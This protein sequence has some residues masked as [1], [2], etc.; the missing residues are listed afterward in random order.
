[1]N[2]SNKTSTGKYAQKIKDL[3]EFTDLHFI[4]L[5]HYPTMSIH[6]LTQDPS[7]TDQLN[8][9]LN[10]LEQ[11]FTLHIDLASLTKAIRKLTK[12]DIVFYDLSLENLLWAY[13]QLYKSCKR[14]NL[15]GFEKLTKDNADGSLFC[16]EGMENYFLLPPNNERAQ[17]R[18]KEIIKTI[19]K[20]AATKKATAA[21]KKQRTKPPFKVAS[22]ASKQAQANIPA[23]AKPETSA[24]S[25]RYLQALSEP[26][27]LF[28][29][30][31]DQVKSSKDFILIEGEDGAEFEL[32]ARELNF[33]AN[34]DRNPLIF[35]DPMRLSISHFKKIERE[36]KEDREIYYCYVGCGADMNS[37]SAEELFEYFEYLK[38]LTKPA[39]RLIIGHAID[40]ESYFSSG[41]RPAIRDF[42]KHAA[43]LSLPPI[44]KRLDDIPLITHSIFSTLRMAHPF[45]R[46]R[47][48]SKSAVVH[49][50]S[51]C[52]DLT[53]STIT[54][55][56]RNAMALGRRDT[57][58]NLELRNLSDNSPTSQH[59]IESLADEEFFKPN[60]N[61]GAA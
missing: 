6:I 22:S 51:E 43:E 2:H 37:H 5:P 21:T 17:I 52:G 46:A 14:T 59:L 44:S 49:L 45:L 60:N 9:L 20:A 35:M 56:I 33:R 41:V 8:T 19:A 27:Q 30:Q 31:I 16:P 36:A 48:I 29:S 25:T 28:L 13:E 53:Y 24:Q 15:I 26:M 40:S 38:G 11:E 4:T 1:M 55:I 58:T 39:L 57:L 42:R 12:A 47:T 32:A 18:I 34:G 3:H 7:V 10:E 54:R 50:Q 23:K 61:S